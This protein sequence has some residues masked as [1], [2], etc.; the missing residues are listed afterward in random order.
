MR[1]ERR[2][3]GSHVVACF[4]VPAMSSPKKNRENLNPDIMLKG[5]EVG[6]DGSLPGKGGEV[7]AA[8]KKS[9]ASL[10]EGRKTPVH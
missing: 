6:D 3:W 1:E 5:G 4:S 9:H 8:F 10:T 2:S 7:G